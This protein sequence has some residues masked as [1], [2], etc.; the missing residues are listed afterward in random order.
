MARSFLAGVIWG[1]VVSGVGLATLSLFHAPPERAVMTPP[2]DGK[3]DT[4]VLTDT[5]DPQAQAQP[6]G[7]VAPPQ[8]QTAFEATAPVK[9]DPSEPGRRPD[10]ETGVDRPEPPATAPLAPPAPA[11]IGADTRPLSPPVIGAAPSAPETSLPAPSGAPIAVQR[12]APVQPGAQFAAPG[13]PDIETQ[14]IIQTGPAQP[15]APAVPQGESALVSDIADD[16]VPAPPAAVADAPLPAPGAAA[17]LSDAAEPPREAAEPVAETAEPPLEAA[18]PVA[19]TLETPRPAIGRPA[20]SLLDQPPAAV[21]D[22]EP[23]PATALAPAAGLVPADGPLVRFAAE[24]EAPAGVPRMA[25]VLIDDGS[26]PL[27]PKGL[28]AFPFPV[29]FAIAPSHPDAAGAAAGYRALGFEVMVLGT[30]PEGAQASDVEVTMAG[31]LDAVPEAVG[32]LEDP[33][34][35]LQESREVAAQVAAI[36]AESGHGLVMQPKGLNTAQKLALRDGVPA[37]TLFRDFDG[38]G[39]D[40][41]MIR[42]T[43]DQA[44]FRAR[45]EGGV[46]MMGRL[47]A[48]TISAL[49]LWGLQ[50]RGDAIVLV[51]V[52]T[53][54]TEAL[55]DAG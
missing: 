31:L 30:M 46:I 47:R 26:G 10:P 6:D 13:A 11:A 36:L 2:L 32:V 50:D 37:V 21:S 44:A 25:M 16:P 1:A 41:S 43:L 7:S 5:P 24:V 14:P 35:S 18:E 34:G 3:V 48:D 23:E 49:V 9:P 55:A 52:S 12:D 29:T 51:P 28:E 19:E 42:R 39:Q 40:A 4:E 53:I 8:P 17:P 33:L 45:Q 38:E 20:N 22:P 54:L 15:P 27:G